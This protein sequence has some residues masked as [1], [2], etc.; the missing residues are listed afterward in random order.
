[1]SKGRLSV[2]DKTPFAFL[3]KR[4]KAKKSCH[5]KPGSRVLR[6]EGS[7]KHMKK[8]ILAGVCLAAVLGVAVWR[9]PCTKAQCDR[10]VDS[11]VAEYSIEVPDIADYKA[12]IW[13][14]TQAQGLTA[15]QLRAQ[16]AAAFADAPARK[17]LN[18]A[19]AADE[20]V[21][22]AGE[23]MAVLQ[24][25]NAERYKNYQLGTGEFAARADYLDTLQL[26]KA[27]F[28]AQ[29]ERELDEGTTGGMVARLWIEDCG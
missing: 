21:N 17:A 18:D 5:T 24:E 13:E 6:A 16:L 2:F 10:I 8:K 29:L 7:V 27:A 12:Y 26:D 11:A 14:E 23:A 1:M 3:V 15:R 25:I 28:K 22:T 9:A 19:R 4:E 20:V